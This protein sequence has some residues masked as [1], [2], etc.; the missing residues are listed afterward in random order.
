M[1]SVVVEKPNEMAVRGAARSRH[2]VLVKSACEC[3]T[4]AFADRT[5]T[6]FTARIRSWSIHA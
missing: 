3:G 6:S 4:P 5:C 1:L 2:P